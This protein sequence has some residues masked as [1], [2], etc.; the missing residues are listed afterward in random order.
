MPLDMYLMELKNV[1]DPYKGNLITRN[2]IIL[3]TFGNRHV[4]ECFPLVEAKNNNGVPS[5]VYQNSRTTIIN[6]DR[7]VFGTRNNKCSSF[8]CLNLMY[9]LTF[10]SQVK[11]VIAIE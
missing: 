8:S 6:A 1:V 5:I 11:I 3:T 4:N 7:Y 2:L 9:L 10:Y